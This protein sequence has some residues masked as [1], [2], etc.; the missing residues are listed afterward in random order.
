MRFA[1]A[2]LITFATN[3]VINVANLFTGIA[4]A[5]LLQPAGRG[6]LATIIL[7]PTIIAALGLMG[8]NWALAREAAAHPGKG[9][10]L[11]RLA[12]VSGL[13]LAFL[14]M[15]AGYFLV[16]LLLPADKQHL[17]FLTRV[18]L[19]WLPLNFVA[20]N[21]IA[22]D[23]GRG[24]WWQYNGLRISVT[25]PY[26]IFILVFWLCGI[27]QVAW[28][29]AALLLTNFI[30]VAIRVC[31]QRRA[32]G[33]GRVRPP[34]LLLILRRGWPFFLAAAS[35]LLVT[36]VDKTL[37]V[38]L[39][40]MDQVGLYAAAFTFASAHAALGGALGI[41]S[42][43]Y[44]AN[45]PDREQQAR[46]LA[47]IFRQATLLYVAAGA[48][49]ALLAPYVIVPLFGVD[50]AAARQPAAILALAT[51]LTS[52]ANVLNEGLRGLGNTYPGIL[53]NLLGAGV[54]AVAAW[55]LV[56]ALGLPGLAYAAV[57]GAMA[58]LGGMIAAALIF[59]KIRPTQLWGLRPL[60]IK[61]LCGRF[62]ALMHRS[63]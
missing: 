21:L 46:K 15:L 2:A 6:E 49:V 38:G 28:F 33:R 24:Q 35:M 23:Q 5:R 19:L 25:L 47:Q 48:G 18:Y 57:C 51:S 9:E 29:V 4:T 41:T 37:A 20:L 13:L 1:K 34:D 17:L 14:A 61:L 43:S 10:D 30:A 54:L 62:Q 44:L 59:L 63:V 52:L 16:P 53:A 55:G 3:I 12:L 40:P 31:L 42:F 27:Y 22:L 50:F 39:L 58:T 60:E 36:Q 32:I 11:A 7:W 26:L 8:V 56:P 45:E